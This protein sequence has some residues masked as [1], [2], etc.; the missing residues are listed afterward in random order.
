MSYL[1]SNNYYYILFYVDE[2]YIMLSHQCPT[3]SNRLKCFFNYGLHHL[4]L[5]ED[6]A[7]SKN[8]PTIT[9]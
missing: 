3:A 7:A 4:F 6:Q 8:R 5:G 9:P 2:F 1:H